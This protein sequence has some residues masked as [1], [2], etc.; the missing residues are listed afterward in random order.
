MLGDPSVRLREAVI[1]GNLLIVKR[2]LRR[3]PEYLTNVDPSNG[4]SSLH[5]ASYNGRYLV[6]VYLI[7]LGHD[8]QELMTT[9][10]GNTCVHLALMNGH[11]QTTHLLLQHFPRFIDRP[12][13][14]GRTPVHIACMR[15][16]YQCLGLL[17][18]VG[19]KLNVQDDGGDT[20]LHICLQYGSIS[21][22]RILVFDGRIVGDNVKNN[23]DLRPSDVAE[24]FDLAKVYAKM[25]KDAQ[26]P[27]VLGK[28]SYSSFRTPV[29]ASK[30]VFDDGP[31]PVLTMNSPYSLYSQPAPTPQL[32]RIP[33]SRR[34]STTRSNKSPGAGA[35]LPS[36]LASKDSSLSASSS[37]LHR[38]PTNITRSS[39]EASPSKNEDAPAPD[40]N[41][42]DANPEASASPLAGS[43]RN[44]PR[45]RV[46]LLNIPITKLRLQGSQ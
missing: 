28:P 32:P 16:H 36:R 23:Y 30:G 21:C 29:L 33:P 24:T 19:A 44:E 15:D 8:K 40:D 27:G 12:G 11:E 37:S 3:F 43:P 42:S 5:Y 4:W 7:Q 17:M 9:F 1:E 18:G 31:S 41:A 2:L 25:L 14:H 10:K 34:P 13:E 26:V 35:P 6:C 46:S 20:P 45:R 39:A 22:M 38:K